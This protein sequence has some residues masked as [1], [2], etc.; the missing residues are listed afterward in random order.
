[1]RLRRLDRILEIVTVHDPDETGRYLICKA[2]E[3]GA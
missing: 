2:R 1:M 3:R